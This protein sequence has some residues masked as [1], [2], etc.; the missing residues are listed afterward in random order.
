MRSPCHLASG[1]GAHVAVVHAVHQ[2]ERRLEVGLRPGV[3][4]A[5]GEQRGGDD[6]VVGE[7]R[8]RQQAY[9]S[10]R[11]SQ[12]EGGFHGVSFLMVLVLGNAALPV[13]GIVKPFICQTPF[14][15]TVGAGT[16]SAAT[17]TS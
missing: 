12:D 3:G 2:P 10:K 16:K 14:V 15:W 5:V 6:G 1:V 9:D 8:G 13:P 4:G 11:R 7:S 17:M